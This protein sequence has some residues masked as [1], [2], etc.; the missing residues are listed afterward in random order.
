L[1]G[2]SP[3]VAP[4]APHALE[5]LREQADRNLASRMVD[6]AALLLRDG[7]PSEALWLL[8][9]ALELDPD[10]SSALGLLPQVRLDGVV[11]TRKKWL[12]MGGLCVV[13]V[14]LA[15]A[16]L[17]HRDHRRPPMAKVVQTRDSGVGERVRLEQGPRRGETLPL[18]EG[19]GVK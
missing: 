9:Q 15:V 11:L 3:S 12:P 7:S 1:V 16:W 6:E 19:R 5:R 10:Q 4:L 13:V 18:R 17:A 2:E 8:Q 14:V